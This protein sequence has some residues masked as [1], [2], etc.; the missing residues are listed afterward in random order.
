MFV[1]DLHNISN[2]QLEKE[3]NLKRLNDIDDT[4]L[5][6]IDYSKPVINIIAHSKRIIRN[7]PRVCFNVEFHNGTI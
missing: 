4:K 7:T 6:V 1:S 3:Y 5:I 2:G